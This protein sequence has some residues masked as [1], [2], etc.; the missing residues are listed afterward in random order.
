MKQNWRQR[1]GAAALAVGLAVS[2][3]ACQQ[4]EVSD[5]KTVHLTDSLSQTTRIDVAPLDAEAAAKLTDFGLRLAWHSMA[6][7]ENALI[8]P[9]SVATALAMTANGAEG[10]TLGEMEA[11]L[12]LD[13]HTLNGVLHAYWSELPESE[14]AVLRS[15]NSIWFTDHA[16][17]TVAQ[18]FLQT[19]EE[20][21]HADLFQAPMNNKTCR[22]INRWVQEKTEGMIPEILDQIQEDA[23]MYLVNALAFEGMWEEP[24]EKWQVQE[25]VFLTDTGMPVKTDFLRS[26]ELYY[27]ENEVATGV[28]KPYQGGAYAF[29]GLL[30]KGD[31][32]L[33]GLLDALDGES[34]QA[35]LRTPQETTVQTILPKFETKYNVELKEVLVDMGMP[36]AFDEQ[37]AEFA[38]LGAST[39]GNIYINQILHQSF[40]SLG[41][42]GTR[43]G[44]A[45]VVEI[46]SG[47]SMMEPEEPKEVLLDQPFLYLLIDT[48]SCVPF[49]IGTMQDPT[50]KAPE[51]LVGGAPMS[52]Q[53]DGVLYESTGKHGSTA[54]RC[55]TLDGEITS[56]VQP[57][58]VPH[59][60]HQSNF[61]TD[62]G[63]QRHGD[64]IE[65]AFGRHWIV[66][67]RAA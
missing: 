34:L 41:E 48:K 66:F 14:Q 25:G 10:K 32:T 40:L 5:G 3:T 42:Q 61:G 20:Y 22:D 8:S 6:S 63:Y 13:K 4:P 39:D 30:P 18:D 27:L 37:Q 55:G 38:G 33:L 44:A 43:A 29:V 53:I 67:E 65:V 7:G 24:Y 1:L 23:V 11:V 16:H 47:C 17:F 52:V 9:M 36:Q 57:W 28:M 50:G 49:L 12:G 51:P 62:W 21:Y 45:T 59:K 56:S 46:K 35:L 2:L 19:C 58:E 64:T 31:L 26:Q 15:A 60:D 54:P